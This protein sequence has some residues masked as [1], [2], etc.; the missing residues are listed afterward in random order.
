MAT[1]SST[2]LNVAGET[3][4]PADSAEAAEPQRRIGTWDVLGVLGLAS[5]MFA[6]ERLLV[7]ALDVPVGRAHAIE[8]ATA[9]CWVAFGVG[10]VALLVAHRPAPR[11]VPRLLTAV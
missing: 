11:S 4:P 9:A 6:L 8:V 2:V 10:L 1:T 7:V 3:P 5:L